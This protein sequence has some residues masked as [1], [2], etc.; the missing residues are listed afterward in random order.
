MENIRPII[1]ILL[2]VFFFCWGYLMYDAWRG[3]K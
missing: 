3:K 2:A 1:E